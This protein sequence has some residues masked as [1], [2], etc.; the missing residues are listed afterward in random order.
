MEDGEHH[1][2][3]EHG[4]QFEDEA[5]HDHDHA[6]LRRSLE[7]EGH[8]DEAGHDDHDHGHGHDATEEIH[9]PVWQ[10]GPGSVID[11][12]LIGLD[13]FTHPE[14]RIVIDDVRFAKHD[15][16]SQVIDPR[17][18]LGHTADT[19]SLR[20]TPRSVIATPVFED[21]DEGSKVVGVVL[22]IQAWERYFE[23]ILPHGVNGLVVDITDTCGKGFSFA[24]DGPHAY[25]RGNGIHHDEKYNHLAVIHDFAEFSLQ[26]EGELDLGADF[27]H[28]EHCVFTSTIYPSQAFEESYRTSAPY[29]F[30]AGVVF[31]FLLTTL[32]FVFDDFLVQRRQ[33]KVLRAA[34]R[35][36]AIVTSL[37]PK[38]VGKRLIE[39]EERNDEEKRKVSRG[40]RFTNAAKD[41]LHNFLNDG[42]TE[43]VSQPNSFAR[44]F[45]RLALEFIN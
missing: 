20:E 30:A 39:E 19:T 37:F 24:I 6:R 31:I 3:D 5:H 17:F 34:Q 29:W 18:L 2:T 28:H 35:T 43:G 40:R 42:Q 7:D 36:T 14:L 9:V 21:F 38:H 41:D 33:G 26:D 25:Y 15:I 23:D 32:V 8:H 22:A 11:S 4:Q 44:C 16:L 10:F 13:L 27:E 1:A 12:S 45:E